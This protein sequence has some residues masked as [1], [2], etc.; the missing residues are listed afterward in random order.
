ME[1]A[2]HPYPPFFS[3]T[4]SFMDSQWRSEQQQMPHT[5]NATSSSGAAAAPLL[6]VSSQHSEE[7]HTF[8]LK[9]S[10]TSIKS[11]SSPSNINEFNSSLNHLRGSS[12]S[13]HFRIE[14]DNCYT[15]LCHFLLSLSFRSCSWQLTHI[16]ERWEE[17]GSNHHA[18]SLLFISKFCGTLSLTT[19]LR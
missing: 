11:S 10:N 6:P 15:I 7:D 12:G 18:C 9:K 8:I 19:L 4:N 16:Q 17:E 2:E 5:L 3:T 1:A 14:D 13:T